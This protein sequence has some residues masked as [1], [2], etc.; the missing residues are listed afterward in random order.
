MQKQK[1]S[2]TH[3]EGYFSSEDDTKRKTDQLSE[4]LKQLGNFIMLVIF[5][6]WKIKFVASSINFIFEKCF[7]NIIYGNNCENE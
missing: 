3:S 7:F 4:K 2:S 5:K 1:V 6:C